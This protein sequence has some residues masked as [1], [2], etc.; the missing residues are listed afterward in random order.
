MTTPAT[1]ASTGPCSP[2][3]IYLGACHSAGVP[4]IAST[5]ATHGI[6]QVP[7]ES[8]CTIAWTDRQYA[9][10]IF[11]KMI[12]AS[13]ASG[14]IPYRTNHYPWLGSVVEKCRLSQRLQLWQTLYPES[15][16]FVP[17]S[18]VLPAQVDAFKKR[19]YHNQTIATPITYILKPAAGKHAAT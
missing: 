5:C 9:D 6:K 17:C 14:S 11:T 8:Q 18:W 16:D 2:H 4:L 10:I 12:A 7:A 15:Y 1:P 13:L 3:S 19:V